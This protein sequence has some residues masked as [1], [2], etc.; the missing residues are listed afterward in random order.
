MQTYLVHMRRPVRLWR[1]LGAWKFIGFQVTIYAMLVSMLAHPWFY[2][3]AA[4]HGL[5]GMRILPESDVLLWLCGA[6][7]ATGYGSAAL[8]IAVTS[9][10]SGMS[11][12]LLSVVFLPVY[13]LAISYAAYCA[14]IDLIQRPFFWEKTAHGVKA[15]QVRN[16]RKRW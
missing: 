13:W 11:R 14:I 1:D 10:R 7:L 15:R 12:R 2:V 6:N 3:V 4:L 8:L 16:H 9:S 5:L